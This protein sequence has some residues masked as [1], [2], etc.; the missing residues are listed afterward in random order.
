MTTRKAPAHAAPHSRRH[1]FRLSLA[2]IYL[3]ALS[4]LIL[5]EYHEHLEVFSAECSLRDETH[6]SL[7]GRSYSRFLEWTR[8]DTAPQVVTVVITA[9]LEDIQNNV[10][11][12]RTY[13]ADMLHVL[14]KSSPGVVVLDK[15]YGP[16]ACTNDPPPPVSSPTPSARPPPRWLLE[17][18]P[19]DS[20]RLSA[21]LASRAAR[22]STSM[23]PTFAT[24]SP[25]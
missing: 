20:R 6:S 4:L 17:R 25:A 19:T 18:T 2:L 12:G 5:W 10:C 21:P 14:A 22:S 13:L 3:A 9:D 24:A 7:Y 11:L 8:S 16:S 15:F 23:P 1:L